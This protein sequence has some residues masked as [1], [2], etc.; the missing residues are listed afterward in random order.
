MAHPENSRQSKRRR[1]TVALISAGLFAGLSAVSGTARAELSGD[2]AILLSGA[3]GEVRLGSVHF[4]ADGSY[5]LSLDDSLFSDHF[6]SMRPFKCMQGPQDMWCH[7]P[8]PYEKAE[9][10]D[11][12]DLHALEY[13][14]LFIHRKSSDYGIDAWNGLYYA[15]RRDGDGLIGELHEV[16][17]NVLAAPPETDAPPITRVDLTAADPDRHWLPQLEIR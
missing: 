10:L 5:S 12:D 4:A 8:Y 2:K 17:L 1:L 6:L 13:D 9:R 16:D 3:A 15:L 7:L 11:G 14:L